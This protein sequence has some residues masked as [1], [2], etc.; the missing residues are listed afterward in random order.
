MSFLGWFF[1]AELICLIIYITLL[2]RKKILLRE[3]EIKVLATAEL[4]YEL[5][6]FTLSDSEKEFFKVLNN[7]EIIK[8]NYYI[9]PQLTLDKLVYIPKEFTNKWIYLNEINRKFVDFTLFDKKTLLPK[10]VIELNGDSHVIDSDVIER[11]KFIKTI[12]EKV[13][14]KILVIPRTDRD[15]DRIK[16]EE[17]IEKLLNNTF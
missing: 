10:I 12:F 5:Q 15:Y 6:Q 4:P 11:D 13:G 1:A 3:Q 2:A 8:N 9:F 17:K 14:I 16:L 7:L